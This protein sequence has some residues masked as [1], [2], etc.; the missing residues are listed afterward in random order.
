MCHSRLQILRSPY[1]ISSL[2][3]YLFYISAGAN[4]KENIFYSFKV[5]NLFAIVEVCVSVFISMFISVSISTSMPWLSSCPLPYPFYV[6][7]HVHHV[8]AMSVSL[9]V[10]VVVFM[11]T[12][13][14]DFAM[15]ISADNFQAMDMDWTKTRT[16]IR[17]QAM[18]MK[19][20]FYGR[21]KITLERT[22]NICFQATCLTCKALEVSWIRQSYQSGGHRSLR[23]TRWEWIQVHF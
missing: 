3:Q 5:C 15:H 8:H 7:C 1:V 12:F 11:F 6:H 14:C 4:W 2:L 22:Y 9:F 18:D 13:M 10:F 19:T 23:P 21:Q 16:Q 20:T 17:T